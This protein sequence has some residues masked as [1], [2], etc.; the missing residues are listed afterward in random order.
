M[1]PA[2]ESILQSSQFIQGKAVADF[3]KPFASLHGMKHC[4]GLGSGTDA[5]HILLS[6]LGIG[7]EDEVVTVSHTFIATA[8]T[9]S[10]TG[11]KPVFIDIDPETYTLDPPK[12]ES[13]I[14]KKT[15]AII[16]VHLYG[17]PAAMDGIMEI[18]RRRQIPV[19]ED[20]CQAHLAEYAGKFV[21]HFGVAA[22]F[23]FY[24][25][26]NLGAYGEAGG[27]TT[28]DDALAAKLRVLR[29]HGQERKYHHVTWGHNYRMDNLQGAVLGVK[30]PHLV[31][32]TAARRRH[33]ASYNEQLRGVGDLVLPVEGKG[34]KH[35][36]HL[37]V[38][39]SQHRDRL[40]T[41]L[42]AKGIGTGLHYPVPL[43][44]QQ[45]YKD[46]GYRKDDF[47]VTE[48]IAE[49][50]LSLPMY[51]ELKDEQIQ[52]VTTAIKEFFD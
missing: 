35:V 44:L 52:Y 50:G 24:P 43:H 46:L 29:N 2:I 51:A 37:Y 9:I 12:L 6:A 27:V 49:R 32:W 36:Y 30:L 16:P 5:L 39:Q 15:R 26:K 4:V 48:R 17:H 13:V 10:L 25:G 23:S 47:P 21:G 33:A 42:S 8:E 1:L 31:E 14:T 11:A 41:H 34:A 18:A 20:A 28:N 40:R 19:I 22:A 7:R 3:E 45:A 38:I